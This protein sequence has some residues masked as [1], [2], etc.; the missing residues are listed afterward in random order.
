MFPFLQRFT[1]AKGREPLPLSGLEEYPD[2]YAAHDAWQAGREQG[3]LPRRVDP[4]NLPPHILKFVLILDLVDEPRDA[5]IRL[6]GDSLRDLYG[7]DPR[8]LSIRDVLGK[9]DSDLL[10]DL[11]YRV[12]RKA[13]PALHARAQVA[14]NGFNWSYSCLL[15]PLAPDGTRVSRVVK[16]VDRESLRNALDAPVP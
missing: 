4:V 7:R 13:S 6:A 14:I 15:L 8:S 10:L 5:V 11:V 16:V 12:A 3:A 9:Q 1:K 2:L